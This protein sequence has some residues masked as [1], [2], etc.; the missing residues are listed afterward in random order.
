V[1][2]RDDSTRA[3]SLQASFGPIRSGVREVV[4]ALLVVIN[5]LPGN[6]IG[7]V[8][9]S[10]NRLTNNKRTP[11]QEGSQPYYQCLAASKVI[12]EVEAGA[13]EL[14]AEKARLEA[15]IQEL[16]K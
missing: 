3:V 12:Q 2:W 8:G 11:V 6:H 4:R 7:W 16:E 14:K 1:A 9:T 5:R 13:A 10:H 15:M